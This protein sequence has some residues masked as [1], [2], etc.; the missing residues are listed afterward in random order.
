MMAYY[1][2]SIMDCEKSNRSYGD[3]GK[4]DMFP[5]KAGTPAAT[6]GNNND[7]P[8]LLDPCVESDVEIID[9]NEAGEIIALSNDPYDVS[10]VEISKRIYNWNCFNIGR[11]KIRSDSKIA[12]QLF[13]MAYELCPDKMAPSIKQICKLVHPDTPYSS[14]AKRY[15]KFKI[16]DKPYEDVI[17]NAIEEAH[18][19]LRHLEQ[20]EE[21]ERL[22]QTP[23]LEQEEK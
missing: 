2:V 13:E 10:R 5:L 7:I 21:Q 1:R 23:C 14:F 22:P 9:C 18:F 8:I 6:Q 15:I 16:H 3:G 4:N 20:R 19:L 12:L 11:K 17:V